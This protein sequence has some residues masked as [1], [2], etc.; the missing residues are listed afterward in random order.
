M[1]DSL[2]ISGI[3]DVKVI[4]QHLLELGAQLFCSSI[5][6][7]TRIIGIGEI[8]LGEHGDDYEKY[9]LEVWVSYRPREQPLALL[10]A[11]SQSGGV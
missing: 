5:D 9:C 2:V 6:L 10:T 7:H 8:K 11:E 4:T 3:W 1:L